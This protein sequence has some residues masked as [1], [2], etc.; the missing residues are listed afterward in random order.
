MRKLLL[1]AVVILVGG[2]A[3]PDAGTVTEVSLVQLIARPLD[4]EGQRVRV[5]GYVT[6]GFEEKAIYLNPQDYENGVLD[7]AVELN[8]GSKKMTL[9][10]NEYGLVEGIFHAKTPTHPVRIGVA[11]IDS[12]TK[13]EPW[14]L[15]AKSRAARA[16]GCW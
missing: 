10:S 1:I 9:E 12:I 2:A 11:E 8:L 3:E 15:S 16:R 4:F 14:F 6:I 13:I 5:V 7:N